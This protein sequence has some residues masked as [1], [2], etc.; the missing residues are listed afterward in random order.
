MSYDRDSYNTLIW[1]KIS[2]NLVF[3]VLSLTQKCRV[4]ILPVVNLCKLNGSAFR[5]IKPEQTNL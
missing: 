5:L 2:W 4:L 1:N 3:D